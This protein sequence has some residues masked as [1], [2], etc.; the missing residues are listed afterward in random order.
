[1]SESRSPVRPL[2]EGGRRTRAP[3]L[4][5]L[6]LLVP[7]LVLGVGPVLGQALPAPQA[8]F[9][10]PPSSHSV[11]APPPEQ[12]GASLSSSG[13]STSAASAR[14]AFTPTGILW[15]NDSLLG[16]F[17]GEQASS[18]ASEPGTDLALLF[19]GA[20]RAGGLAPSN[21]T[22]V[23]WYDNQTEHR[24]ITPA[25]LTARSGASLA[26]DAGASPPRFVLFGGETTGPTYLNDTWW[27]WPQNLSWENACPATCHA[28]SPEWGAVMVGDSGADLLVLYGGANYLHNALASTW[29][30]TTASGWTNVSSATAPPALLQP[31][32]AEQSGP[33]GLLLFGG[34][35]AS[36]A[37]SNETWQL[38]WSSYSWSM[39]PAQASPTGRSGC[40]LAPAAAGNGYVLYG[41][42]NATTYYSDAWTFNT[43]SLRWEDLGA[44]LAGPRAYP[45]LVDWVAQGVD[46]L[47]LYGGASNSGGIASS[48]SFVGTFLPAAPPSL[49]APVIPEP[50][51]GAPWSVTVEASATGGLS[52]VQVNLSVQYPGGGSIRGDDLSLLNGTPQ[53]GNWTATLPAPSRSGTLTWT[54]SALDSLG[55]SSSQVGDTP[56]GEAQGL[57]Q[58]FVYG[59]VSLSGHPQAAPIAGADVFVNGTGAGNSSVLRTGS[60]GGFSLPLLAG[61]YQIAAT[62]AGFASEANHTVIAWGNTSAFDF[63]LPSVATTSSSQVNFLGNVTVSDTSPIE[64]LNGTEIWVNG[65]SNG[66]RYPESLTSPNGIYQFDLQPNATYAATFLLP[67]YAVATFTFTL[68]WGEVVYHNVQLVPNN[69]AD[70]LVVDLSL[71]SDTPVTGSTLT[72]NVTVVT[73]AKVPVSSGSVELALTRPGI[74][75]IE[76]QP[77][78]LSPQGTLSASFPTPSHL[79][80][81]TSYSLVAY[82]SATSFP[83]VRTN[84]SLTITPV[85]PP[86][87]T[88]SGGPSPTPWTTY[89]ALGALGAA[90]A[91]LV[92]FILYTRNPSRVEE[93]FLIYKGGKL[94]WHASRTA[95]ADLEPEVVTG[96]LQAVQGFVERSFSP[97]GGHLN[98]LD[99]ANMKLHIVRG[100][101]LTAAALLSGRNPKE[102]VR[103]VSVALQDMEHAWQAN[104][105]DWDG[106][107]A[108]LPHLRNYVDALLN[109]YYYR[110]T[111]LKVAAGVPA[112]P[113]GAEK[114]VPPPPPSR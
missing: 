64:Y 33:G 107:T 114:A 10:A 74:D 109:G 37:L 84:V 48:S 24:V 70:E 98:V 54:L 42:I 15:A 21:A 1:M 28:P 55:G 45:S 12:R 101:R 49:G 100:D 19:G 8:A 93:I 6:G 60:D 16:A 108:S 97:E 4:V 36:G 103:E 94:V 61:T 113:E 99:F 31:C 58:G 11:A 47:W 34:A 83:E 86:P 71:S 40:A 17:P 41:G 59:L 25:A 7:L 110:H 78:P 92:G 35:G 62:A 79:T 53:D 111:Q 22:Y 112:P 52:I 73:G 56:I 102:T 105:A 32:A 96:M 18:A 65:S 27:F 2:P 104:L 39:V 80:A 90:V 46:A 44:Q 69:P 43:T 82:V 29:A 51:V 85:P 57:L 23:L 63:L 26:W 88:T 20:N 68:T 95:R 106:T 89:A 66:L 67:R 91:L 81:N 87:L 50:Q 30:Y 13:R 76:I 3:F 77:Q 14:P 38:T 72:V 9:V 75:I 5:F